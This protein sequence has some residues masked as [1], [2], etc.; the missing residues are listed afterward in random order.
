VVA[1]YEASVDD[2]LAMTMG[3]Y[4]S[5]EK[6]GVAHH[7]IDVAQAAGEQYQVFDLGAHD[8]HGEMYL[9]VA[10][11]KRPGQVT[12]VFIDRVFL[13]REKP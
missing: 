5:R 11:P 4:D 12:N 3:I 13:V 10:P 8:L 9:W 2:G 7:R 1:R 6:T